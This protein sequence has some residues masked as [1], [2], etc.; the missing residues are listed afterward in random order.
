MPRP[1]GHRFRHDTLSNVTY[2]VALKDIPYDVPWNCPSCHIVHDHKTFHFWLD[3]HGTVIVSIAIKDELEK[4]EGHGLTY[5][6]D[7]IEPPIIKLSVGSNAPQIVRPRVE[8]P[9]YVHQ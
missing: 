1:I 3:T 2:L 8:S 6:G 9:V 4:R 5:V 7:V